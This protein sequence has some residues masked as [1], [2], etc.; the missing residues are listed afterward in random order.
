[1]EDTLYFKDI[2]RRPL[3]P[4]EAESWAVGRLCRT[5]QAMLT[6]CSSS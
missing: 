5:S 4:D 6:I 2:E 1:M 3:V